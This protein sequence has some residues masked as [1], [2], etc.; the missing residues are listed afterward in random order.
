MA[1][2]QDCWDVIKK[3]TMGVFLDFY[4]HSK[5]ERILNAAFIVLTPKIPGT[6][7]LKDFQLVSLVSGVYKIIAKVFAKD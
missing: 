7:D 2:F 6:I 5:F 4:A 1:F 3:D